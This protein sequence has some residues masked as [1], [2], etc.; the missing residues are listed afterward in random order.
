MSEFGRLETRPLRLGW[1]HE[2]FDFIPWLADHLEMLGEALDL[3]LSYVD[4][5]H[6]V[7]RYSLDILL[8][9]DQGRVV[10]VENQIEP[11]NHDHLGK[12]LTYCAGTDAKVLIWIAERF[13]EE[14]VAALEWLNSNSLDG[15]HP[16]SLAPAARPHGRPRRLSAW[17]D[18]LTTFVAY[19]A[20]QAKGTRS[21]RSQ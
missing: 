15:G 1:K 10:I 18:I 4:Q 6:A 2:S 21:G 16:A 19:P 7:G 17:A 12:L 8:E 20:R 13:N 11:A 14:H 3:S 5:E 9:D